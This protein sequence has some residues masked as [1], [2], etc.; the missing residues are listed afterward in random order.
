[1]GVGHISVRK[2]QDFSKTPSAGLDH[3]GDRD[4]HVILTNG[5]RAEEKHHELLDQ[6]VSRLFVS[7]AS[8]LRA[9]RNFDVDDLPA[10][11][12]P[13]LIPGCATAAGLR[14]H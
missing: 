4:R 13:P 5:S 7:R 2:R 6:A 1:M 12:Q 8:G 14:V 11:P 9:R 3:D 10:P